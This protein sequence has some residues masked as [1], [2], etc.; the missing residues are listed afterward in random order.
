MVVAFRPYLGLLI[1]SR[2]LSSALVYIP[3]TCFY[4]FCFEFAFD[5]EALFDRIPLYK[6]HLVAQ[7]FPPVPLGSDPSEAGTLVSFSTYAP[8]G[9]DDPPSGFEF[10]AIMAS[11]F[12]SSKSI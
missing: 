8:R 9:N 6:A 4:C 7:P 2:D 1:P 5:L 11:G 10:A 3:P 12:F